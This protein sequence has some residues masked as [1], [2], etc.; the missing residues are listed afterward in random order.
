MKILF[1]SELF[2]PYIGGV[3]RMSQRLIAD[4]KQRGH[5]FTVLTSHD[6]MK[7]PDQDDLD[8]VPVYRYCFR[9]TL[10]SANPREFLSVRKQI[11]TRLIDDPPDLVHFYAAGSNLFYIYPLV[12]D[13]GL[14]VIVT[15]HNEIVQQLSATGDS[16][17]IQVLRQSN[18]VVACSEAVLRGTLEIVPEIEER[19]S[20][21]RNGF[22]LGQF[23]PGPVPTVPP[24]L[25]CLSR[26]VP[27][28]R[29][30]WAIQAMRNVVD[31]YPD[32]RLKIAGEGPEQERLE[33]LVA[34][35]GLGNIVE[36]LGSVPPG[37]VPGLLEQ[38]TALLMPSSHEGLPIAA[39]EAAL[40]GR[41]IIATDVGGLSEVVKHGESG[42][43]VPPDDS[44]SFSDAVL[45]LLSD[46]PRL[47]EMG[48]EARRFATESFGQERHNDEYH[49]LYERF[50]R[51]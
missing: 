34:N 42:E 26:L 30:H 27:Q 49:R 44:S 50:A 51:I 31:R 7:L 37:S 12:V 18:W 9:K 43:L 5:E 48:A 4:L 14:P 40:V 22:D 28:K 1:C 13:S 24:R 16:M 39:I 29:V 45:R 35:Y 32:A 21:I 20:T 3:E 15:L 38:S 23:E 19:S 33:E 41:P 47:V 17:L 36:F 2:W 10:S 46:P 11:A 25:L 8:G 6:E